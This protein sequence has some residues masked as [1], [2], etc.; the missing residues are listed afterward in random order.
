MFWTCSLFVVVVVVISAC[1]FFCILH[2]HVLFVFVITAWANVWISPIFT[3]SAATLA[4][5]ATRTRAS[6]STSEMESIL[7]I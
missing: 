7:M 6:I 5:K 2:Y 4:A 3:F 1:C